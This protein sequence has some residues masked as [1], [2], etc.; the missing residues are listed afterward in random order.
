MIV[1]RIGN[2]QYL[3]FSKSQSDECTC[4]LPKQNIAL[5]DLY[6]GP[7]ILFEKMTPI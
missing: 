3:T 6:Y 2:V 5:N 1:N 4:S 7:M